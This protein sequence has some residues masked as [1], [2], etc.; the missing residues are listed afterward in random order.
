MTKYT[1]LSMWLCT[2]FDNGAMMTDAHLFT[3][4]QEESDEVGGKF[5]KENYIHDGWTL[6]HEDCGFM[7]F[8]RGEE[9]VELVQWQ[10]FTHDTFLV[11]ANLRMEA[12]DGLCVQKNMV[13]EGL[14]YQ[15]YPH[16]KD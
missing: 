3:W 15:F 13:I 9:R 4:E 8:V 12:G 1:S 6:T 2:V 16:L 14:F 10:V 11:D 7:V 5:F